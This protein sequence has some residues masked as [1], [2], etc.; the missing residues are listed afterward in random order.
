MENISVNSQKKYKDIGQ[1][2]FALE[3][4]EASKKH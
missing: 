4:I 2:E 3:V 1:D